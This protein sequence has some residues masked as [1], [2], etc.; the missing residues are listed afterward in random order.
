MPAPLS[1]IKFVPLR[2]RDLGKIVALEQVCFP[3]D[4]WTREMYE[5]ELG[6]SLARYVGAW[7]G[8]ELV[9]YGGVWLLPDEAHIV[10]LAVAPLWRRRGLAR[11]L[12]RMMLGLAVG[13]GLGMA[14]LLVR[15]GNRAAQRLYA[16]MGWT[17]AKAVPRYYA[18]G[19]DGLLMQMLLPGRGEDSL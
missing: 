15:R 3:E 19:E 5:E 7:Q 1:E 13:R 10:N 9:G 4:A 16:G 12:I 18:D 2:R 14:S 17:V 11:R 6:N 8:R